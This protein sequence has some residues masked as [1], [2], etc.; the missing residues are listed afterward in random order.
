MMR[1][2]CRCRRLVCQRAEPG[3]H[4]RRPSEHSGARAGPVGE[5]LAGAG[6]G[7]CRAPRRAG[8]RSAGRRHRTRRDHT[9][10][11]RTRPDPHRAVAV[12]RDRQHRVLGHPAGDPDRHRAIAADPAQHALRAR[13]FPGAGQRQ[14]RRRRS[15]G[16]RPAA[17]RCQR[18]RADRRRLA[19]DG[20]R[21][22]GVRADGAQSPR[23][24]SKRPRSRS[25]IRRS[26]CAT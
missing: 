20:R 15:L 19:T 6:S 18:L 12:R 3:Q 10:P 26:R 14:W 1:C 23:R 21:T 24:A 8:K 17:A 13:A 2:A 9:E 5:P 11:A 7:V 16:R 4:G 22:G 25:P